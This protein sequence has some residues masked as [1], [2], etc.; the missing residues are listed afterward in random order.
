MRL[1]RYTGVGREIGS[2]ELGIKRISRRK[3]DLG[4]ELYIYMRPDHRKIG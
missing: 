4:E 3:T 2:H 1:M